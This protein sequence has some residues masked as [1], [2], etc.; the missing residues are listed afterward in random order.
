MEH[1]RSAKDWAVSSIPDSIWA[2]LRC[3]HFGRGIISTVG[4]ATRPPVTIQLTTTALHILK[5]DGTTIRWPYGE[6][7]QTQGAYEGEQVRFE[8]GVPR[9]LPFSPQYK[10]LQDRAQP[11]SIIPGSGPYGY[12]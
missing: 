8:H 9:T 1:H 6:I 2:E 7:A 5:A 11:I 10:R 12:E 3:R 4:T